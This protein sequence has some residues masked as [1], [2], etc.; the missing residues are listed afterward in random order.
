MW[1]VG[2]EFLEGQLEALVLLAQAG[3]LGAF[4]FAVGVVQLLDQGFTQALAFL[5]ALLQLGD[6]AAGTERQRGAGAGGLFGLGQWGQQQQAQQ[7]GQRTLTHR[8]S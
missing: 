4:A 7:Q 1:G 6:L 3:E 8:N 2:L 5:Q